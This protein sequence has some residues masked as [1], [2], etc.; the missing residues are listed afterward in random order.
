M[1]ECESREGIREKERMKKRWRAE[2]RKREVG[3]SDGRER[4]ERASER[5]MGESEGDRNIRVI[6]ERVDN[7]SPLDGA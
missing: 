5:A 2:E 1:R 3:E 6:M 4:R 7:L